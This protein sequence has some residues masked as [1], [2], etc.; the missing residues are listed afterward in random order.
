MNLVITT[1]L[2]ES[3]EPETERAVNYSDSLHRDWLKRHL[4]WAIL[5]GRSIEITQEAENETH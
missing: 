1:Y 5:N 3:D 4:H 2:G